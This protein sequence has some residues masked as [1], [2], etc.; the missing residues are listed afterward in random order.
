MLGS[1]FSDSSLAILEASFKRWMALVDVHLDIQNDAILE[2]PS[3]P[4]MLLARCG[5][6]KSHG[7]LMAKNEATYDYL[8]QSVAVIGKTVK[9]KND[10]GSITNEVVP[11]IDGKKVRVWPATERTAL[12]RLMYPQSVMDRNQPIET[13][14]KK[15]LYMS[16]ISPDNP[17]PLVAGLSNKELCLY[18]EAFHMDSFHEN[19]LIFKARPELVQA[20][21][22]D[23][24][25]DKQPYRCNSGCLSAGPYVQPVF[26]GKAPLTKET[27]VDFGFNNL[28]PKAKKARFN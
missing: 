13:M 17:H 9:K 22:V 3:K 5:H 7:V 26:Y 12:L 16:G 28:A 11:G 2:D 18:G 10:D 14:F 20:I 4:P 19:V 23:R 6:M 1:S 25:S 15:S 8:K 24:N 21:L 27:E